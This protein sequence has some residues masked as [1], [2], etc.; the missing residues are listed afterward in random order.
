MQDIG[1]TFEIKRPETKN[2]LVYIYTV[3]L[4]PHGKCKPKTYNRYTHKK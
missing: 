4:K 3:K 2:S 1:N